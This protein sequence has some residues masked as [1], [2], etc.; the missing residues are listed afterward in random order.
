MRFRER[1]GNSCDKG[2]DY[3]EGY[4]G[5]VYRAKRQTACFHRQGQKG[6]FAAARRGEISGTHRRYGIAVKR[7]RKRTIAAN[8]VIS[9]IVGKI[10]SIISA[11]NGKKHISLAPPREVLGKCPKCGGNIYKFV[12]N[13]K[14]VF[15]CENS[16]KSCFFRVYEDDYFFTSKGK[17][18]SEDILK[19][20]LLRGRAVISGFKSERTGKPY[21]ATV[22]FKDRVDKN[23]CA[24]VGFGMEFDKKPK[25]KGGK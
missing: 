16:P 14:A 13:N 24:R 6:Y 11:E 18:F 25:M 10:K 17:T 22:F 4:Q 20:L 7:N 2:G 15:Y 1:F 5:R 21:E 3:R 9:G 8:E 23:G 12:K 19:L